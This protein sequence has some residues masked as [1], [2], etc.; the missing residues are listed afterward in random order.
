MEE[1]GGDASLKPS[2]Y[3]SLERNCQKSPASLPSGSGRE[4]KNPSSIRLKQTSRRPPRAMLM[5]T[6][7][8]F[9]LLLFWR[10]PSLCQHKALP[11]SSH[12]LAHLN[13][14][15]AAASCD[16]GWPWGFWGDPDF[17]ISISPFSSCQSIPPDVPS[18]A[19]LSDT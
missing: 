6:S 11:C 3:K 16:Q 14:G 1:E 4:I 15:G 13:Q 19:P 8:S 12:R 5:L 17:S 9:S 18:L 2:E 10:Q 7:D